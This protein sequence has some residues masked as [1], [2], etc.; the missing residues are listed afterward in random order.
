LIATTLWQSRWPYNGFLTKLS[1]PWT[2][3]EEDRRAGGA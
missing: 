3:R 1:L 2:K